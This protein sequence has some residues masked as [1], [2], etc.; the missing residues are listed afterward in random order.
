MPIT[1]PRE[2][3]VARD[4]MS[5]PWMTPTPSVRNS[6]TNCRIG[7]P[8]NRSYSRHIQSSVAPGNTSRKRAMKSPPPCCAS[9]IDNGMPRTREMFA[10]DA[11]TSLCSLVELCHFVAHLDEQGVTC[12]LVYDDAETRVML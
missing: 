8:T 5:A 2:M 6:P 3:A 4:D 10:I 9:V 11:F 12:F 7:L 1:P